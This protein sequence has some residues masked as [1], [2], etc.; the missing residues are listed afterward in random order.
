MNI[1]HDI[2]LALEHH[3]AGRLQEAARLY[4]QLTVAAPGDARPW[5][6]L[7]AIAM[8]SGNFARA[9]ELVNRALELD[10]T[11]A[12]GHYHLAASLAKLDRLSDAVA[13]YRQALR[14]QPLHADAHRNLAGVL[15]Q[16]NEL[17]GALTHAHKALELSPNAA[18]FQILGEILYQR[19]QWN[20]A[21]EAFQRAT[22]IDPYS[23]PSYNNMGNILQLQLDYDRAEAN[24]RRSVELDP[25]SSAV[26][27]NLGM[28]RMRLGRLDESI[29]AH[30]RA[31]ALAPESALARNALGVSL[32]EQGVP[33]EAADC[34]TRAQQLDAN[35]VEALPNLSL[36]RLMQGRAADAVDCCLQAIT[37]RP[38]YH[39]A[40]S[41]LLFALIFHPDDDPA[42]LLAEQIRWGQRHADY[43]SAVVS[44]H[45]NDPTPHRR[46]R[47]GYASPNFRQHCQA[48]FT[49][50]LL[51]NHD[52]QAFEIYCYSDVTQPDSHT[53]RLQKQADIWRD[54]ARLSDEQLA[55]QIRADKIDILVDLTMHLANNRALVFARKPAPVQVCWLAYPG[56]TGMA[57]MDYRISDALLDP[58]QVG[59]K[60]YVEKTVRLPDA[61]WCYDPLDDTSTDDAST[62]DTSTVNSLPANRSGHV[63]FGCLNN[64][65]KVNPSVLAVWAGVLNAVP[66]SRMLILAAQG[67]HRQQT[68]DT[69]Q[70]LGVESHRITFL[71][72]RPRVEYLELYHS[73][74]IA[75]DTFP[76]NGHTTSLDGLWMGVPV[77]TLVG[78]SVTGRAGLCQLTILG[79]ADLVAYDARQYVRIASNLAADLPRLSALRAALRERLAASPLMD[80]PR[81]AR[82][83]ED[84][85]RSMW[86]KCCQQAA[87]PQPAPATT[88]SMIP[89]LIHQLWKD[90]NLSPRYEAFSQSWKQ[91]HPGWQYTLWTDAMLR[92]F[93]ETR[94]PALLRIY[95]GYSN[96][97]CRADLGRY[98]I[99][100]ELGGVYADLD[101][102]CLK[103]ID[104]LLPADGLAIA[105]EPQ[106]HADSPWARERGITAI[107]CPSFIACQAR[108]PV[109]ESVFM[110]IAAAAHLPDPLDATG[111]F[112]LS[113]VLTNLSASSNMTYLPSHLIYP[114]TRQQCVDGLASDLDFWEQRTREAYVLHYWDGTWYSHQSPR[115]DLPAHIPLHI[116][117]PSKPPVSWAGFPAVPMISCLMVTSRR[118]QLA[119]RSIACFLSQT[120]ANKQLLIVSATPE[121]EL[122]EHIRRLGRPEIKLLHYSQPE[123]NLGVLR[124]HAVDHAQGDLVCIW[125]DDDLFDPE[126][127]SVQVNALRQ[128]GAGACVLH[129]IV[130]WWP[131][132]QRLGITAPRA[133]EGSLLAFKSRLPRYAPLDKA[134]DTPVMR[135]LLTDVRVAC[136]DQPRLYVYVVHENNT[137]PVKQF[138]HWWETATARFAGTRYRSTLLELARRFPPGVL[139]VDR[140]AVPQLADS[141]ALQVTTLQVTCV[142][143]TRGRPL[144]ARQA[145]DCFVAQSYPHREL[146]I[147]TEAID[148]SLRAYIDHLSHARIHVFEVGEIGLT[149][150]EL[151]NMAVDRASGELVCQW[152]D[153]D[154][155]HPDRLT[156]QVRALSN[157]NADACLL[158]R[159]MI[160][161]P[162]EQR[163]AISN[164]RAWEGSLLARR[165]KMPRYPAIARGEDTLVVDHLMKHHRVIT[166]DLPHLYLYIVHGGN[167]WNADHFKPQW[168]T[169]TQRYVGDAYTQMLATLEPGY[170]V[171][172]TTYLD[173]P[174][175]R[176][177]V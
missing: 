20:A 9:L 113:R 73:I 137:S 167:T 97:I 130:L 6:F 7:G 27:T 74:D 118:P 53:R 37:R 134:E 62:D 114:M 89:Q 122:V 107:A 98:V 8:Q 46:L 153:D 143:V 17:D 21:M 160:W 127:L 72:P 120:Y 135:A 79:L 56:S 29:Q 70:N 23:A 151:R 172:S 168:N 26:W 150:G 174:A 68:L 59:D 158:S 148:P 100:H 31:V 115:H 129:R 57:A 164:A 44:P 18:S 5:H 16:L 83:M 152:D 78:K 13:S 55:E 66:N 1:A 28:V 163:L 84:A 75:L 175:D 140:S 116:E 173:Q 45:E 142:M 4:E 90:E 88:A 93:I 40:H 177:L 61:F 128:C 132:K 121:P 162:R 49:V 131:A 104:T 144:Q 32:L 86:E 96:S 94:K 136:V 48:L 39:Q 11:L 155:Y 41:S 50:P 105:Y 33:D 119:E 87:A 111:P 19:H 95:D 101:C 22:E 170:P 106:A 51:T 145:V 80:A 109:W 52:H 71:T 124:N 38:D 58:P 165:S 77:V 156:E 159:W 35:C 112:L 123:A 30:R 76:S 60:L 10:P 138:E 69:L 2:R 67:R 63:T 146:L 176:P 91:Q 139:Q 154:L 117:N 24:Y 133:W 161:W 25:R 64:F 157:A 103:P 125:D 99:L 82:N 34:F 102:V 43:L 169:A 42:K 54:V 110:A 149:L 85:Y 15:R 171:L 92:K 47:I 12:D 166:I 14:L 108:H 81:F 65:C 141:F 147:V 3:R 36:V 126:R